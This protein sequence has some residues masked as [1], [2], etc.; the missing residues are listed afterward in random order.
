MMTH[1]N[2]MFDLLVDGE[3]SPERRRQLLAH[4]D[5]EP[6][7]WKRCALAFLEAQSFRE[8]FTDLLVADHSSVDRHWYHVLQS[9]VLKEQYVLRQCP[10]HPLWY[11]R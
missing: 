7:G 10:P 2:D 9:D 11:R 1:R 6:D 4:L 5:S 8:S 3:L